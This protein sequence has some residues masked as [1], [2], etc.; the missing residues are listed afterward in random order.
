MTVGEETGDR[1]GDLATPSP[2]RSQQ[3]RDVCLAPERHCGGRFWVLRASDDEEDSE[4]EE[5]SEAS[6][7]VSLKYLCQTPKSVHGRDLSEHSTELAS[8]QLKRINRQR[9]QR[10]AAT[11]A[12]E[13]QLSEGT[14]SPPSMP[15]GMQSC[16]SKA[17][18]LP[19]LE[20][21]TFVDDGV[22]EW[23]V[24]RR[25]RWSPAINKTSRDPK[26]SDFSNDRR[27]G[28]S[29][30]WAGASVR[31]RCGP[32]D[33]LRRRSSIKVDIRSD[34]SLD[35]KQVKVGSQI[36][37]RAF[38]NLLGLAWR[39]VETG[40]PVVSRRRDPPM[41]GD[42]GQGGF[43]PG[44]E[45][46]NPGRGGY[47]ARGGFG[48]GRGGANARGR[49]GGRGVQGSR[50]A[51]G[52]GAGRGG[53]GGGR[54]AQGNGFGRHFEQGEASGSAG[55]NG[56]QGYR[57]E[58][59][60]GGA[61]H[62]QR[63]VNHF[64]NRSYNNQSRWNN[65]AR[66]GYQ[67]NYRNNGQFQS[68]RSGIDAD[69][70]Q[71]TVQAV[72]A[73][74]T[75]AQKTTDHVGGVAV[76]GAVG[77]DAGAGVPNMNV[78]VSAAAPTT[79]QQHVEVANPT[80]SDAKEVGSKGKDAEEQG[81]LKKKKEDKTSCFRCKKPGHYI[82]DCP[83]PYCDLCESVN[84]VSSACHL[85]HAPKP[86]AVMHGYANEALMFF[87]FACGAFK[88]KVE[89]P[90][91]GFFK[92]HFEVETGQGTQE[93]NMVEANND[94]DGND[95]AH[96]GD[97]HN[98]GGHDMDMDHRGNDTDAT[99]NNNQNGVSNV[100]NGVEGMQ[101]Q[102]ELFDAIQVG[103]MSVQL[104]NPDPM[105]RVSG[106]GSVLVGPREGRSSSAIGQQPATPAGGPLLPRET[107]GSMH[108]QALSAEAAVA[109]GQQR[110]TAAGDALQPRGPGS[111][112]RG[113]QLDALQPAAQQ[114][115]Q[116]ALASGGQ[117]HAL[118]GSSA[119]DEDGT[120]AP[121]VVSSAQK[122]MPATEAPAEKRGGD[123]YLIIANDGQMIGTQG[124]D[125]LGSSVSSFVA[126]KGTI[127]TSSM[128][129]SL[130]QPMDGIKGRM[131]NK[132]E[133]D[134]VGFQGGMRNDS[135][136]KTNVQPTLDDIIAFGGIPKAS[137]EVRTSSR[138]ENRPDVDMPQLEKAK[139]IAQ[140]REND[141]LNDSLHMARIEQKKANEE[142]TLNMSNTFQ[143]E[144]EAALNKI[145]MLEEQ[146]DEKQ[147][148]ELDIEQ[149]RGQL[150]VVK[151]M[152]RD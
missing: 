53:F 65:N 23:T 95:G 145:L 17:R 47:Q 152:E 48:T 89:N 141:V 51:Q 101:E 37:G 135:S 40:E 143:K 2:A 50:G 98:D 136:I 41:N 49:Q 42:G 138:L 67:P 85:L 8:R 139:R 76:L 119:A 31:A 130:D 142:F 5:S 146:L 18:V 44:R 38:R 19:V 35:P 66:G 96:H 84:H 104:N 9:N 33:W 83:T 72:V 128:V 74:V 126:A 77:N 131:E 103:T 133:E 127:L 117:Q 110:A 36:A 129:G 6:S 81:P 116:H 94:N 75:A 144:M 69:L 118:Q 73:A 97:G 71:Q 102:L 63:D 24:V 100:N 122:I 12:M 55:M 20:P 112:M 147:K 14:W 34:V 150:E 56:G 105:L 27:L 52:F 3:V 86:T 54:H 99:S 124:E 25:R 123:D 11:T 57:E 46:F 109:I 28:S 80:V 32:N 15:L 39:R 22:G 115:Q 114:M 64:G 148:L 45:G 108:G 90:R 26:I 70:L 92:L 106:S 7:N 140:M 88:A 134:Q 68:S 16:K 79:S 82:D 149:L 78:A 93:V 29:T 87:E 30:F 13:L 111:S 121:D 21:M 61:G 120:G 10:T 58:N 107:R 1:R 113:Q 132:E 62:F 137:T 4:E 59:W 43:N 60:G 125:S 91:R 151:H